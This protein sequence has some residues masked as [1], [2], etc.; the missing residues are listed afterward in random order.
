MGSSPVIT[1]C[2]FIG[3]RGDDC[4]GIACYGESQPVLDR[5]IIAGS[6]SGGAVFCQ[7]SGSCTVTLLC[8]DIYGN[9]GGDWTGCIA[10]EYG[11]NGNFSADPLFCDELNGDFSLQTCSPCLP[12][13]HP[14]GYDCGGV[15]GAFGSGCDC[16]T[17]TEPTTWGS[18]KAMYR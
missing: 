13:N 10:A 12:G 6:T 7:G 11:T 5:T 3:N 1:G 16:G 4:G 18:I 17:A 2:T 8:C 15:L 14:D 9:V